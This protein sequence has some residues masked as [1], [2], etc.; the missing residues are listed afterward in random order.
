MSL[1]WGRIYGRFGSA[2]VRRALDKLATTGHADLTDGRLQ[3]QAV[4]VRE[5]FK[6]FINRAFLSPYFDVVWR[7]PIGLQAGVGYGTESGNSIAR[8]G[9]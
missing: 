5:G 4:F 8:S 2:I 9:E 3:A 1:A 7:R 6:D